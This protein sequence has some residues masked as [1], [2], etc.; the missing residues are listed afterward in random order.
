MNQSE[1]CLILGYFEVNLL[2]YRASCLLSCV[3][4]NSILIKAIPKAKHG[5]HFGFSTK[6]LMILL[7]CVCVYVYVFSCMHILQYS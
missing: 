7:V 2:W 4:V 5:S 1:L 6:F 3:C